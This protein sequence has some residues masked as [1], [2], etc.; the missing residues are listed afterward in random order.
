MKTHIINIVAA[1]VL[2]IG[3]AGVSL[4]H[5]DVVASPPLAPRMLNGTIDGI[6]S[7]ER[8]LT[9]HSE[10]TDLWM[11]VAVGDGDM[12]KGLKKGDRV[13]VTL[14]E[15]GVATKINKTAAIKGTSDAAS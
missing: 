11:F 3:G 8:L 7:L 2:F 5:A 6:D 15:Q 9:I 10:K 12:L 13:V 4:G 1:I 14:D